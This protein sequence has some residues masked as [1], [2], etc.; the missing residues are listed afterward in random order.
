MQLLMRTD[1]YNILHRLQ[2]RCQQLLD[3]R[4]EIGSVC[5]HILKYV[6]QVTRFLPSS[7]QL[8]T[9][10]QGANIPSGPGRTSHH[11]YMLSSNMLP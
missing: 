9:P 6:I 5:P 3:C 4:H 10:L 2:I 11:V 7:L 8:A 1:L